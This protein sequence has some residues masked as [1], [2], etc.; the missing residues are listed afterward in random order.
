[1][2][3]LQTFSNIRIVISSVANLTYLT[4]LI[5]LTLKEHN[6]I[7]VELVMEMDVLAGIALS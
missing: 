4:Q 1:M 6:T 2:L 7:I 3:V 5:L